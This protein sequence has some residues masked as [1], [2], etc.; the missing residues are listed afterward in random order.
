VEVVRNGQRV[1]PIVAAGADRAER[2]ILRGARSAQRSSNA[3]IV[4]RP[5]PGRVAYLDFTEMSAGES[6]FAHVLD[7]LFD[8][9]NADSSVAVVVDLRRNGGGNSALGDRLLTYLTDR[10]YPN[11][12]RKDWKMSKRYRTY[13]A[14]L[15]SPWVRWLPFSWFGSSGHRLFGPPDG[16]I[17]SFTPST[18]DA[19]VHPGP[20]ARRVARPFCTIIGTGTFSSAMLLANTIKQGRLGPLVGEPTGEP[21]NSFG[22]VY[23]FMLPLTG[24]HG[25]IASAAFV[26]DPDSTANAHGVIPDVIVPRTRADVAAG[27]DRA[28]DAAVDACRVRAGS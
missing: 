12:E 17:V 8:R 22:E 23:P 21:P 3:G 25:Q 28:L 13:L 20:N 5:L 16:T 2:D 4:Y 9:I 18:D 19:L 10:P 26:L 15:V 1:G 7:S 24:L 14:S 11:G 27:R 6:R